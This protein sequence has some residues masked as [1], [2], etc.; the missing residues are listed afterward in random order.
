MAETKPAPT[1]GVTESDFGD[2][3]CYLGSDEILW[4]WANAP[5]DVPFNGESTIHIPLPDGY[6][7]TGG[8]GSQPTR[9]FNPDHRPA[10]GSA[11]LIDA[12]TTVPVTIGSA[13]EDKIQFLTKAMESVEPEEF[14]NADLPEDRVLEAVAY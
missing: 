6:V 5:I 11:D 8:R 3:Y 2:Q 14:R 12:R 9:L 10:D 13:M 7:M 1:Y 4:D